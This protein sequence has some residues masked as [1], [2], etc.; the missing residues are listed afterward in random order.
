MIW[1]AVGHGSVAAGFLQTVTGFGSATVLF[2]KAIDLVKENH[3]ELAVVEATQSG[4]VLFTAL[5]GVVSLKDAIP[6]TI[7]IVGI[8][9]I[10]VGMI[11]NSLLAYALYGV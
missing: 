4:E 11:L 1:L 7:G 9:I 6:D 3:R 8:A 2:F 5:M 10:I